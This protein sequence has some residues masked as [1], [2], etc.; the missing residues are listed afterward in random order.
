[1]CRYE[2]VIM[3][4]QTN[5]PVVPAPI[6]TGPSGQSSVEQHKIFAIIGY[7][8]PILFFIPMLSSEGKQ[9]KFAMFHANQQLVLLLAWLI[10]W[11]L[12]FLK[13]GFFID[14]FALIC[15]ILGIVSAAEETTKPLPLIGGIKLLK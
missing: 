4:E 1:M 11:M 9:N 5:Q 15:A 14:I 8:V 6:T 12:M 10:G 13:I 7:I 2:H 3:D